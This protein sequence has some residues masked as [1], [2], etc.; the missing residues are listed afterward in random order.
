MKKVRD[1]LLMLPDDLACKAL[2]H[3]RA[4]RN[5]RFHTLEANCISDAINRA[6]HWQA[7][8]EGDEFWRELNRQY[9]NLEIKNLETYGKQR[10]KIENQ[11]QEI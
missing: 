5:D 6:F 7:T 11:N 9:E 8:P 3:F 2:T 4:Q 1:L 10:I